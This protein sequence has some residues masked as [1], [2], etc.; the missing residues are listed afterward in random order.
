MGASLYRGREDSILKGQQAHGIVKGTRAIMKL[1]GT[2]FRT[3]VASALVFAVILGM[4]SALLCPF[5]CSAQHYGARPEGGQAV[6]SISGHDCCLGHSG[7][8]REISS[9]LAHCHHADESA[10]YLTSAGGAGLQTHI[11][12]RVG[13]VCDLPPQNPLISQIKHSWLS[14]PGYYTSGRTICQKLSILLI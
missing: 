14:P 12:L 2:S 10:A 11:L 1:T 8:S 4:S 3:A 9:S 5:I 7:G 13:A 6:V